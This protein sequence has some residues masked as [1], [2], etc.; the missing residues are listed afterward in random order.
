[1]V[2]PEVLLGVLSGVGPC[3]VPDAVLGLVAGLLPELAQ[4]KAVM[5]HSALA[6]YCHLG[7]FVLAFSPLVAFLSS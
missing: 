6:L 7:V 2:L 4:V 1:V 3:L 5:T